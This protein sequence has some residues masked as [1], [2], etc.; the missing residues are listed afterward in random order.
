MSRTMFWP[1][2]CLILAGVLC[3]P[4]LAQSITEEVGAG[5]GVEP[6]MVTLNFPETVTLEMLIDYVA[7]RHNINFIHQGNV[8]GQQF[9]LKAPRRIPA[10]AL[11]S[12][13]E[14]AMQM[15]GL[16]LV[17][18][19]V[20]GT[21]RIER[22]VQMT[23]LTPGLD[24]DDANTSVMGKG[25]SAVTRVFELNN[26]TA[27]QAST[28]VT[29]FLA[30]AQ[31][32]MITLTEHDMLVITDYGSNMGRLAQ[33]LALV[34]QPGPPVQVRFIPIE[35]AK[36]EILQTKVE[37]LLSA[38][39][40]IAG[41]QHARD[42]PMLMA[43]DRT[44]QII[45]IGTDEMVEDA[46]RVI[47][48]ID[49]P[50]NL[51]TQLYQFK[52]VEAGSIDNLTMSLIGE[53]AADR[54]YKSV[55]D[56]NANILVVT[57]T[58]EIH[59]QVVSLKETMD[60][61][62]AEAASPIRFYKLENADVAEVMA[63]LRGIEEAGGL[64]SDEQ[65]AEAETD[66]SGPEVINAGPTEAQVN[67]GAGSVDFSRFA[68]NASGAELPEARILADKPSNTLIVIA[69]PAMQQVYEKLIRRLDVRRP[70]VLIEATV[71]IL[72]TSDSF[73][74]G[75]EIHSDESV[76]DGVLLNFSQ[77]GLST[78]DPNTGS[79]SIS[80]GTGFNG[81]L[82]GTD[83]AQVVIR[84]LETDSRT[85]ILSRP[86]VLVNDN[87][88]GKLSSESEEPFTTT[89]QVTGAP[90]TTSFGG[91][92]TAG[93]TI[94]ITPQISEGDYLTL[95]YGITLSSF[96]GTG[97]DGVPPP[98]SSDEISSKVTI[99]DGYTI[100]VG[101]LTRENVFEDISKVPFLGS[102][103]I[104]EYLFSSR[105]TNKNQSTLFVFIR[106]TILRDD[107]FKDLKFLSS[108]SVARAEL[109]DEFPVSQPLEIE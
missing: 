28:I 101:G 75:V 27:S 63:T 9:T 72:D 71:V 95:E 80:P 5:D 26:T 15:H 90:S 109:T 65:A 93:T 69:P 2:A 41:G 98:R 87:A 34:D 89:S 52:Y 74:L 40:K 8:L 105:S 30:A 84:A 47:H 18:T 51:T 36:A 39:G 45:V 48:A 53:L 79:I 107:K 97:A 86:S 29:P 108:E 64:G 56:E 66:G 91:F 82:L 103:P 99:P 88:T 81:A 83:I 61:P 6:N 67:R 12:L 50:V 4:I 46:I 58:D 22:S 32:N 33:M 104:V 44:N 38:K 19:D 78:G 55:I 24:S 73:S 62:Q 70:Q 1:I 14:S 60:Q 10:D 20:P 94:N 7:K 25:I 3:R 106:A 43:D 85:R 16:V 21:M 68:P 77:F 100:V 17:P 42:Q 13:L 37:Q 76:G 59:R 35:H 54:L 49:T 102:I 57:A 96:S 11:M 92:A 31:A 23:K